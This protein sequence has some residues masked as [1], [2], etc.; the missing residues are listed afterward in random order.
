M[1]EKIM[2]VDDD[3][4]M[5]ALLEIILKRKGFSVVTADGAYRALRLIER[6]KPDLFILD[7]MMPGITGLE[8]CQQLRS[9][10]DT[11]HIPILLLSGWSD[12]EAAQRGLTVGANDYLSKTSSHTHLVSRVEA[13]L[14]GHRQQLRSAI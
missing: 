10:P 7:V 5:L 8:L 12:S 13:L 2:V 6:E 9:R 3:P 14:N 1:N 11:A 4:G